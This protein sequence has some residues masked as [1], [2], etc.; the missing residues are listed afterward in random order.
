[1][2]KNTRL[3]LTKM[4][5]NKIFCVLFMLKIILV[6]PQPTGNKIVLKEKFNTSKIRIEKKIVPQIPKFCLKNILENIENVN[7]Q[8]ASQ[9]TKSECNNFK[10]NFM[11]KADNHDLYTCIEKSSNYCE[12]TEQ[13]ITFCFY[14]T[15]MFSFCSLIGYYEASF[16]PFIIDL[17]SII[18]FLIILL[19][20]LATYY[21]NKQKKKKEEKQ[22]NNKNEVQNYIRE[23]T[24]TRPKISY[25]G[26]YK[27][28][29]NFY[30]DKPTDF[31]NFMAQHEIFC[32]KCK[33]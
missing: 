29:P 28:T 31:K 1:M 2:V 13:I 23:S 4:T 12:K 7:F 22:K 24:E 8:T 21:R 33:Q 5:K 3:D 26:C 6:C 25:Y 30:L 32:L 9:E 17:T 19:T 14:Q 10:K 20:T 27:C 16:G 18:R 11:E 15:S